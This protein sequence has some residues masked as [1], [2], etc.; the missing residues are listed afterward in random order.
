MAAR[1]AVWEDDDADD[2]PDYKSF[3]KR[4]SPNHSS[5]NRNGQETGSRTTRFQRLS[6]PKT[7]NLEESKVSKHPVSTKRM[8][9]SLSGD[10]NQ[11]S[12]LYYETGSSKSWNKIEPT[13][14]DT[15]TKTNGGP[16]R[17]RYPRHFHEYKH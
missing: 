16:T 8:D 12:L 1:Q 17:R 13:G 2:I 15:L 9:V 7:Q 10:D 11:V 4:C 14:S 3:S 6:S 5:R